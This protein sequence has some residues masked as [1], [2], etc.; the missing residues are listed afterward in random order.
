MLMRDVAHETR[1]GGEAFAGAFA[2]PVVTV[3]ERREST[4][5]V[6]VSGQTQRE[7]PRATERRRC[8]HAQRGQCSRS[9][10]SERAPKPAREPALAVPHDTWV[11]PSEQT[12]T[13]KLRSQR[14]A[15]MSQTAVGC[16][17]A[18]RH[19]SHH[20]QVWVRA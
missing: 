8:V 6:A 13:A 10:L 15:R 4:Q 17:G 1:N 18:T 14:P 3:T 2:A 16:Q 11:H 19:E 20:A 12:E 7:Q 9:E 5:V